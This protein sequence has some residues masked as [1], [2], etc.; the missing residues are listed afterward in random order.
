MTAVGYWPIPRNFKKVQEF[1]ALANFSRRL[2]ERDSPIFPP[3]NGHFR[4]GTK[5]QWIE[6][7][8][9]SCQNLEETF[10]CAPI[11]AHFNPV[12]S[13]N[14]ESDASN[15]AKS[16]VLSHQ[17]SQ[18]NKWPPVVFYFKKF[19]PAEFKYAVH[20]K[21]LGAIVACIEE[22]SYLLGS[23]T[24]TIVVFTDHCNQTYLNTKRVRKPR[25]GR[26]V[27]SPTEYNF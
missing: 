8:Q 20:N 9:F 21:E 26:W 2:I 7:C 24:Y 3:L 22:K 5:F 13:T 16:G 14:V 6:A 23:C 15:F 10:T 4:K 11:L 27:V 19:N 17:H 12:F 1:L 18:H 25:Q